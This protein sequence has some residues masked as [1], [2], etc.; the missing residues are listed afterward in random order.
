MRS[1][2]KNGKVKW[3]KFWGTD[4]NGKMGQILVDGGS[5]KLFL[6]FG[7]KLFYFMMHTY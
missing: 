1:T 4:E 7:L 6:D 2:R 3:D 5:I